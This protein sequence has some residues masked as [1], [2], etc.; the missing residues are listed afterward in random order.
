MLF[1]KSSILEKNVG[2][3]SRFELFYHY[4]S[5]LTCM[6]SVTVEIIFY[7]APLL[8]LVLEIE[9]KLKETTANVF[10]DGSMGV[11]V[12]ETT[13]HSSIVMVVSPS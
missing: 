2:C 7:L 3:R 8:T 1:T 10:V 6:M 9:P 4:I 13:R 5:F 12:S 11:M